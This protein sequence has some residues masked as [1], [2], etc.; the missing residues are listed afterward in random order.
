MSQGNLQFMSSVQPSSPRF[1]KPKRISMFL[2][3]LVGISHDSVNHLPG[4]AHLSICSFVCRASCQI[5]LRY[6]ASGRHPSGFSDH[7]TDRN[8]DCHWQPAS[9]T[10]SAHYIYPVSHFIKKPSIT[11]S[12]LAIYSVLPFSN[13]PVCIPHISSQ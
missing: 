11:L 9:S 10:A 8:L 4:F 2:V 1:E 13:S 6:L 7:L 3:L 5:T 12:R